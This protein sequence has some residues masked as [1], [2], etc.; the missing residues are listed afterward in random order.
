MIRNYITLQGFS[1]AAE[2]PTIHT[3]AQDDACERGGEH[4]YAGTVVIGYV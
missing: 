2:S 4:R 1:T 3:I